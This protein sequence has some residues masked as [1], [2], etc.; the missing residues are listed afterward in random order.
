MPRQRTPTYLYFVL[1]IS[2]AFLGSQLLMSLL[3]K[4]SDI[5]DE[6]DIFHS[7]T[8]GGQSDQPL[9]SGARD[10]HQFDDA[11]KH[12]SPGSFQLNND[13]ICH[14]MLTCKDI[15]DNVNAIQHIGGGA[16][17]Q[18]YLARWKKYQVILSNLSHPSFTDDFLYGA[19]MLQQFQP[20]PF[21]TRLLGF[22]LSIPAIVTEYHSFGSLEN[23][24]SILKEKDEDNVVTRFK[25]CLDYVKIIN[26][27]HSSPTGTH[28]MCDS[29]DLTKTLSQFLVTSD[30]HLVINDLDALPVVDSSKGS[31]IKC[32]HREI[33]GDFVAPEQ[34]WPYS[35][36]EFND[37]QMPGYD[38]KTDIWKIPAV[39]DY[40]LGEDVHGDV[41]RFN[42]FKL[43]QK[44]SIKDPTLRPTAAE[45]LKGYLDV[46]Q[47]L[48]L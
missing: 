5:L 21:V 38:E 43:H 24:N 8:T 2:L 48:K 33:V 46:Q 4:T 23:I 13:G 28:V 40:L 3:M 9:D 39:V 45:V 1:I 20:N 34:L 25:L 7:L 14:P 17:K 16:V 42:L 37:A 31:S 35:G 10:K 19:E 32:G 41:V 22:C 18:V 44:C 15:Q 27:L 6:I 36:V 11:N 12:C 26:F 30:L 47:T 29:N